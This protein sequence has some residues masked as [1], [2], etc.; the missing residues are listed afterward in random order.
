MEH[1]K[2]ISTRDSYR[3]DRGAEFKWHNANYGLLVDVWQL[4]AQFFSKRA[5][6]NRLIYNKG[7]HGGNQSKTKCQIDKD[8]EEGIECGD[9]WL[10]DSQHHWIRECNHQAARTPEASKYGKE[11]NL[12]TIWNNYKIIHN[13]SIGLVHVK[14][15][16]PLN[17]QGE[18]TT[19]E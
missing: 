19:M 17:K 6:I 7:W 2:Y 10:P 12:P 11:G 18:L 4:S 9:C 5:S 8:R 1:R 15:H 16:G 14:A 13:K 3:I